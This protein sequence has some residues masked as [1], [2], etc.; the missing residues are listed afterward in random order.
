[1]LVC[2]CCGIAGNYVASDLVE[3]SE[4]HPC[5]YVFGE[6]GG[7]EEGK[8]GLPFVGPSGKLLRGLLNR[9]DITYKLD[10]V[11]PHAMSRTP[12][13][14]EVMQA[15]QTHAAERVDISPFTKVVA[16]GTTASQWLVGKK[17]TTTRG[18][19]WYNNRLGV[20]VFCIGHPAAVLRP[21]PKGKTREQMRAEFE[22]D[23]TCLG[24]WARG[25]DKTNTYTYTI[26]ALPTG[27]SKVFPGMLTAMDLETAGLGGEVL[28]V[29]LTAGEG[30]AHY[31]IQPDLTD[32][33]QLIRTQPSVWHNAAYD[34]GILGDTTT[35]VDDTMIMA[36]VLGKP[37]ASLQALAAYEFGIYHQ[38]IKDTLEEARVS[39]V[40]QLP[41][42][43]LAAKAGED[44]DL[45]LRLYRR[46]N[47]ELYQ[48]DLTS[49]YNLE[50]QVAPII[51][52]VEAN[53]MLLDMTRLQE[54]EQT[55]QSTTNYLYSQ[56]SEVMEFDVYTYRRPL[57]CKACGGTGMLLSDGF[58]AEGCSVCAGTGKINERITWRNPQSPYQVANHLKRLG[59]DVGATAKADELAGIDHPFARDMMQY[60]RA[61]KMLEFVQGLTTESKDSIIHPHFK[62]MGAISGRL[63]SSSK[64]NPL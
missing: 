53:G 44:V 23:V 62:Q 45:T 33:R 38:S 36:R 56:L 13:Q 1:M 14:A 34:L 46:Y 47:Q 17:I 6:A 7:Y 41:P 61:K 31:I 49:I 55:N 25:N 9:L 35:I 29:A 51:R 59:Y 22:S 2:D 64:E 43:I 4:P 37:F 32:L 40:D 63:S 12:T 39:E 48:R 8:V 18:R 10:N 54:L 60:R 24:A 57:K 27:F 30:E 16:V 21:P 42:E 11:V 58:V 3:G 28:G 19:A 50:K 26:D 5:L 20:D 15:W 52:Q